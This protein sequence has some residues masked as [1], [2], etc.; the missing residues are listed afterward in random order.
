MKKTFHAAALILFCCADAAWA[1]NYYVRKSGRDTNLGTSAGAAFQTISR[2]MT[3]AMPGD[4]IYV[5][6]GTYSE[7]VT[8]VRAGTSTGKIRIIG[9][10]TGAY[11]GDKAGN[12]LISATGG[13][14]VSILHD[15]IEFEQMIMTGGAT[16]LL[17]NATN[18]TGIAVKTSTIRYGT[19]SSISIPAGR[20]T[21]SSSTIQGKKN[22]RAGPIEATS[23]GSL[24]ASACNFTYL[25]GAFAQTSNGTSMIER[26]TFNAVGDTWT[27]DVAGGSVTLKSNLFRT[28][29]ASG[30]G[31]RV[32]SG[33]AAIWNNTLCSSGSTA[34]Q[35]TG[36][37][38]TFRN[39]IISQSTNG[40]VYSAGSLTASNNLYWSNGTNYT[41]VA[42]GANDV[43]ADPRFVNA[44]SNWALRTG[45]PAI[46]AGYAATNIVPLDRQGVARPS[47][48]AWDIGAYE[49]MGPSAAVPYFCDFESASTAPAEWSTTT[50]NTSTGLSRFSGPHANNTVGVRLQTTPDTDYTIILDVYLHNTWDGDHASYGPDRFMVAVDGE[51]KFVASYARPNAGFVFDWPDMP[52]LWTAALYGSS[53]GVYRRVVVDFTATNDVSFI[54]FL[55]SA[56]QGWSDEGWSIDNVRVVPATAS[57]QYRPRFVEVGR[58][59]GFAQT[60]ATQKLGLVVGD[61]DGNGYQDVMQASSAG[62]RLT[63]NTEGGFTTSNMGATTGQ[64]AVFDANNDGF[65][66]LAWTTT[67]STE[68]VSVLRGNGTGLFTA[69]ATL[70]TATTITS[71]DAL[72]V[73]DLNNDG[74]CD[75]AVF[76]NS[77]NY[78]LLATPN[79]IL[80]ST[81]T[82][83]PGSSN[84]SPS[85][86][87]NASGGAALVTASVSTF[88]YTVSNSIFPTAATDRRDGKYVCSGDINNDGAPDFFYNGLG[89]TFFVSDGTGRYTRTAL[90][91]SSGL[92]DSDANGA[93]LADLNNDNILELISPNVRGA[94]TYWGRSSTTGNFSDQTSARGLNGIANAASVAAGD[95]DNDGDQDL[96]ITMVSGQV[97]LY[98]NSGAPSYAFTLNLL[99]GVSTENA[100]GDAVFVDSDNDG[101]LD[102]AFNSTS[103]TYP[104][105]LYRNQGTYVYGEE[106]PKNYLMVRMVGRGAGATNWAGVGVRVELWNAAN[107]TFL[108]RR[109]IGAAR[110]AG[111]QDP[112][113]AH[114]GGVNPNL[115][116]TVRVISGSHTYSAQ[117]TPGSALTTIGGVDVPQ[118]YTYTE[119]PGTNVRIVR[120]REVSQDD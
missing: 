97:R 36:G 46:D 82:V 41:G 104:S 81:T 83:S 51:N 79:G 110:G 18:A 111:G 28:V 62:S 69:M 114:F 52:E 85:Q 96:L 98:A 107:T 86:V 27:V 74:Y 22:D 102:V 8:T 49:L 93:T 56:M 105:R 54:S 91:F 87:P 19:T 95:Y 2:A 73:A 113:W 6:K 14:V 103:A 90:G 106:S 75:I 71:T 55:T 11:T 70:G 25:R 34:V 37:A 94:L 47:A 78:A 117:V 61:V 92:T 15:H 33:A 99:E 101:Y 40:L 39:N 12:I 5:G 35:I 30:M 10:K 20:L 1:T 53:D 31:V 32:Q 108:Q 112:L 116:Y 3:S 120:W 4:V 58:Q 13:T 57:A 23:T 26:S 63:L 38:V 109:E 84:G 29:A 80:T 67:A 65:L 45:S 9:D 60:G 16:T 42:A 100:Y 43:L 64:M 59:D 7:R 89:G 44:S 76:G 48:V 77:G 17:V 88:T 118:L 72:A 66:D 24:L 119:P 115:P 68:G 21:L 50:T